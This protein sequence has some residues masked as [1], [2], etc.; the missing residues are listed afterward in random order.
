MGPMITLYL[1]SYP[2]QLVYQKMNTG[3]YKHTLMHNNPLSIWHNYIVL[4]M[5]NFG[6]IIYNHTIINCFHLFCLPVSH[7]EPV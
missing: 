7:F 1:G 5:I 2:G 4:D 3:K 6:L